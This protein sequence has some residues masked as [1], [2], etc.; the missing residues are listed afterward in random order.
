[1]RWEQ[2]LTSQGTG[3][4]GSTGARRPRNA[5]RQNLCA[6]EN[7]M[8]A[9]CSV[10]GT[11]EVGGVCQSCPKM[12]QLLPIRRI[13][14]VVLVSWTVSLKISSIQLP[15]QLFIPFSGSCDRAAERSS[16]GHTSVSSRRSSP[17]PPRQDTELQWNFEPAAEQETRQ[18]LQQKTPTCKFLQSLLLEAGDCPVISRQA[19]IV[20]CRHS[21]VGIFSS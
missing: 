18:E 8:F 13:R 4:F 10:G 5:A 16:A 6:S 20:L 9:V 2:G 17:P 3:S 19:C 1:M 12:S 11:H 15:L 14:Q 7:S 21:K